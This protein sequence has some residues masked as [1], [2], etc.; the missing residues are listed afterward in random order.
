MAAS[1]ALESWLATNCSDLVSD[2]V[3]SGTFEGDDSGLKFVNFI[4][5][6]IQYQLRCWLA[7][8]KMYTYSETA[9]MRQ[10]GKKVNLIAQFY[11]I[12]A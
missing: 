6:R 9:T 12:K 11:G 1:A 5:I 3:S 2:G 7:G 10:T 4:F 8:I